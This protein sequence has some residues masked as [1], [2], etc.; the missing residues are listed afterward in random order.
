[1]H[2]YCLLLE[3]LG[4]IVTIVSYDSTHTA[5]GCS[6]HFVE[7]KMLLFQWKW[8]KEFQLTV[9][10]YIDG[11]KVIRLIIRPMLNELYLNWFTQL[12]FNS[13]SINFVTFCLLSKFKIKLKLSKSIKYMFHKVF[14]DYKLWIIR[15]CVN[16]N[17]RSNEI[18]RCKFKFTDQVKILLKV[19]CQQMK[20]Y[21]ISLCRVFDNFYI[22]GMLFNT[23]GVI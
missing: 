22:R 4:N 9:C 20:I 8:I 6:T 1:M 2:P 18:L 13:N 19:Q 10:Q 14:V 17:C 12:Q 21:Q 15:K 5:K 7:L 3:I 23:M 16:T 11:K